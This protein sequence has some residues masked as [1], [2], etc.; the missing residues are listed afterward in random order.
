MAD[1]FAVDPDALINAA[2]GVRSLM[3]E[4]ADKDVNDVDC[5]PVAVGHEGL[6]A[7]LQ[8]FCDRWDHGVFYLTRDGEELASQLNATAD[9]YLHDDLAG[10]KDMGGN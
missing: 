7:T 4:L 2:A 10:M 6:A 3:D 1:E 8:E 5:E 9:Q